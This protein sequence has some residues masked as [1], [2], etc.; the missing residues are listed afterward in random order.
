[1]PAIDRGGRT[2]AFEDTGEPG[3]RPVVLFHGAP[4]SRLFSPDPAATAAAGVRLI[5]FDRPGYGRS[6]PLVDRRV[7]DAAA[8]VVALLD[9][10]D[11]DAR[12]SSAGRAAVRSRSRP[13]CTRPSASPDSRS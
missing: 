8:D 9:H 10:L 7:A 11:I 6:D 4:G 13:R 1:M 5:T 3:G 12:R 2:L